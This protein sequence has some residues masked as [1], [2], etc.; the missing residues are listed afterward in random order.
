VDDADLAALYSGALAF[1]SPSLYEGFGLP[2]LEAMQ[3]GVPVIGSNSS[4]LPEVIGDAGWT[5]DPDDSSGIAQ[6]VVDLYGNT[7]LRAEMSARS[8]ARAA[9]FSWERC[10]RETIEVYRAVLDG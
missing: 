4:S 7:A 10:T 5:L 2:P 6:A 8:L 3:C 9:R 1:V